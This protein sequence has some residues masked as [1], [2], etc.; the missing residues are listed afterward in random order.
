VWKRLEESSASPSPYFKTKFGLLHHMSLDVPATSLSIF[1]CSV[2]LWAVW[3]Q[4]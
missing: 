1:R 2:L 3:T 4:K